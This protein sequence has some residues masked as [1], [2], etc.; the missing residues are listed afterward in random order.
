M[1]P[2]SPLLLLLLILNRA[3]AYRLYRSAAA[4]AV[5]GD[6]RADA[7]RRAP[8]CFG[9]PDREFTPASHVSICDPGAGCGDHGLGVPTGAQAPP[10]VLSK[11]GGG[12]GGGFGGRVRRRS[13]AVSLAGLL[14]KGRPLF[15][16]FGSFS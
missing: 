1:P 4:P 2:L 5:A 3:E 10:F 9:F 8:G 13:N 14:A 16:E 15:I 6:W 7:H 11:A 12:D